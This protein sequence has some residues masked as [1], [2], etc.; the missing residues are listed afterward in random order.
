MVVK[1]ASEA[2]HVS[3]EVTTRQWRQW[4]QSLLWWAGEG[5]DEPE[6]PVSHLRPYFLML[7]ADDPRVD[8]ARALSLLDEALGTARS[9]GEGFCESEIFRVRAGIHRDAGRQD[10]AA[11]DY[12]DAVALAQTRGGR[13]L[14]MRALTDWARLPGSLAE[15][16]DQLRACTV[17]V[18]AGGPSRSLDE[19]LVVL[20]S[21]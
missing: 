6:L 17:D 15:V 5:I 20:R 4:S 11:N 1:L 12:A 9:S 13:M 21:S 7:L 14:E 8:E 3:D 19:A 18:E 16:R 2:F 10:D